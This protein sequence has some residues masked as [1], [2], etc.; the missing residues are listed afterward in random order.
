MVD[1][2]PVF[3]DIML[4]FA[5]C[6][7]FIFETTKPPCV[8]FLLLLRVSSLGEAW[9][10]PRLSIPRAKVPGGQSTYNYNGAVYRLAE[11]GDQCWFADNLR[12]TAFQNGDGIEYADNGGA[13]PSFGAPRRGV[14]DNNDG[15]AAQQGYFY[16]FY[17]IQDSRG[18]CPAEYRV[19]TTT[20]FSNMVAQVIQLYGSNDNALFRAPGTL[21]MAV[22][23]TKLFVS[24]SI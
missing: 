24:G 13:W 5:V 22:F 18:L 19:P 9:A 2:N 7:L 17:A 12:T 4:L 10:L 8:H 1:I 23:G 15:F 6:L 11:I 14:R 20:D 3:V 16:N 21:A